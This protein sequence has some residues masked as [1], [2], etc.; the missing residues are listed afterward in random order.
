MSSRRCAASGAD[1]LRAVFY[2]RT[3]PA[4]EV[5]QFGE[6]ETP[7]PG[8]GE[9]LVE[10]A[11]SGV[12]P[13]DTKGRSGWTGR[14]M[15]HPRIIPHSDGA[16]RIV[17]VGDGVDRARVGER[18]WICRADHRAGMGAAAEF[19][20]VPADCAVVLP[21]DVPFAAGASLGVPA[22][23]A[24]MAVFA[25]GPVSGLD[26]LV[27]GGAGAVACYAIQFARQDDARVFATVSSPEKAAHARRYGADAIIDYTRED[28]ATRVLA[29]TDGRGVD[30]IV[31]VDFGANL[32][33][34]VAMIAPH[35]VIASYSSS[36]VREPVFPC[37]DLAPKDVPVR[38]VQGKIIPD[39]T[40]LAGVALITQLMRGGALIHPPAI[41]FPF[42]HTAAAHAALESGTTTGKIVVEGPGA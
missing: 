15:P 39:A 19:V 37:Y 11:A 22:L 23:T 27:Q 1:S 29:L 42:Q 7:R 2:E 24:F 12:N 4:A 40:R 33:A 41:T 26:V 25:G 17:A 6:V 10:I 38:I 34:D 35:G 31:E 30:R 13:H 16:G 9:V 8:H 36:R 20:A 18:V 5:L 21:D 32:A 14:P 28:V 3:G